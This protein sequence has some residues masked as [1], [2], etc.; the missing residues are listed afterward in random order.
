MNEQRCQGL[1]RILRQSLSALALSA[2]EQ[3]RATGSPLSRLRVVFKG[4]T[5][6]FLWLPAPRSSTVMPLSINMKCRF[7]QIFLIISF[8]LCLSACA[9]PPGTPLTHGLAVTEPR[10]D[11]IVGVWAADPADLKRM[12]ERGKHSGVSPKFIFKAD[13]SYTAENMRDT[14]IEPFEQERGEFK[15]YSGE[16]ELVK[17][18]HWAIGFSSEVPNA[19]TFKY[20]LEHRFNGHPKFLFEV[21]IGDPDSGEI[22]TF[23]KQ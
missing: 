22:L 15:T 8:A 14:W 4:L 17:A 18:D 16:W 6:L 2:S 5:V 20:L 13:G 10:K 1:E 11:E 21:V 19:Y 9:L 12:R 3:I 7:A 23:V